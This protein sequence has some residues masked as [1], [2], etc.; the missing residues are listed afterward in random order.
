MAKWLFN[1][2]SEETN[3]SMYK[4]D[5]IFEKIKRVFQTEKPKEK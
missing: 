3:R 1:N 5:N 4:D 2:L